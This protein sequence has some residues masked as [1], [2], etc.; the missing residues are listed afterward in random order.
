MIAANELRIG[1][2]VYNPIDKRYGQLVAIEQG[3]RPIINGGKFG[4]LE[5]G[6]VSFSGFDCLHPIPLTPE[7]LEKCGFKLVSKHSFWNFQNKN[8]FYVSMWMEDEPIAGFEKKGCCYA[9]ESYTEISTVH[10]LQNYYFF[11]YRKE[12]EINLNNQ[13]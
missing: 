6:T 1:N 12:L 7:I 8:G 2:W 3:N 10:W 11:N 5:N 13:P 4:F 9:G